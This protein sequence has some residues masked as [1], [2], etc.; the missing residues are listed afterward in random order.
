[1]YF[2][3]AKNV[4]HYE[5]QPQK[6]A[7]SIMRSCFAWGNRD[8]GEKAHFRARISGLGLGPL[9]MHHI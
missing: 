5:L 6:K 3:E 8:F 2:P 4:I 1:M 7:R 9:T